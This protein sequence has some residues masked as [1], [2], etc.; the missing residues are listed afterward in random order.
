M[1]NK[2]TFKAIVFCQFTKMVSMISQLLK[3]ISTASPIRRTYMFEL[4]RAKSQQSRSRVSQQFRQSKGD[5]V[6][7]TTDVSAR[8]VDYPGT[9]R[10]IQLGVPSTADTHVHR[11]GPMDRAP[12]LAARPT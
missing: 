8:G 4:T 9:T 7:V 3:D 1:D 5:S 10:V 12:A 6:Q 11:I 2:D